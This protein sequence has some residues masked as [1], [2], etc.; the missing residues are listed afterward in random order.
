MPQLAKIDNDA[1]SFDMPYYDPLTDN[2]WNIS[3]GELEWKWSVLFY[4]PA[5]FTFVC[6]T[7][8]KDLE[9]SKEDLNISKNDKIS[10]S[11]TEIRRMFLEKKVPPTWYMR[12]EI[13]NMIVESI[14][15]K[16]D[17]FV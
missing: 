15:A 14:K 16:E 4:Y 8:L 2:E 13:S 6:P 11:G 10:I 9:E 7:E 12:S 17:I 3:L 1:P 5:D